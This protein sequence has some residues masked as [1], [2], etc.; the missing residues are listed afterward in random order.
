MWC[1]CVA[2]AC[3]CVHRSFFAVLR[4]RALSLSV[5]PCAA[6]FPLSTK[7]RHGQHSGIIVFSLPFFFGCLKH[8]TNLAILSHTLQLP[9]HACT[10]TAKGQRFHTPSIHR[11]IQSSPQFLGFTFAL[12]FRFVQFFRH[13]GPTTAPLQSRSLTFRDGNSKLTCLTH[14]VR[15]NGAT[16]ANRA[17]TKDLKRN[18]SSSAAAATVDKIAAPLSGSSF[19][20]ERERERARRER[21]FSSRISTTLGQEEDPLR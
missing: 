4:F 18:P 19:S 6:F 12:V 7:N 14:S 15:S 1:V 9:P 5:V 17:R 21:T 10:S 2:R 8:Y 11:T 3:V 16:T 13:T 20:L